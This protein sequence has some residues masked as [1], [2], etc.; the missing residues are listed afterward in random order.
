MERATR[1]LI[2]KLTSCIKEKDRK[3]WKRFNYHPTRKAFNNGREAGGL[4]YV[5]GFFF[6]LTREGGM[7]IRK[8]CGSLHEVGVF[9]LVQPFKFFLTLSCVILKRQGRK[10]L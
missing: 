1:R 7:P 4:M 2:V 3:T 8:A 5:L 9:G 6:C 10:L